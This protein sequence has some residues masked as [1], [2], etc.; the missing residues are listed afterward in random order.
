MVQIRECLILTCLI[1]FALEASAQD[2]HQNENQRIAASEIVGKIRS[3]VPVAYENVYID[4][5]LNL[6]KIERPVVSPLRMI[7]STINGSF[8][9]NGITFMSSLD[10]GG[11]VIS[12]NFTAVGVKFDSDASFAGAHFLRGA[13]FHLAKF[14]GIANFVGANFHGP[15]SLDYAQFSKLASFEGAAFWN[16]ASFANAQFLGDTSLEKAHFLNGASMEFTRFNQLV[17]F[18]RSVFHGEVSFANSEFRGTAN[19]I[20]VKFD[21]N[22]I[23]MGARF[24]SDATF[25]GSIFSKAAVFGLTT[26]EGFSDFSNAVFDSVAF[27][28]LAKLEDNTRFVNTTFNSDLIL[29]SSRIYTMQMENA[30]FS[31]NSKVALNEADF[32]RVIA[33]WSSLKDHLV[34]DS[35]AYLALVKNYKN[36]E[37]RDDADDCYYQYRRIT[38]SMEPWGLAK[39]IDVISWLSCGYGVRPSYTIFWSMFLIFIFGILF[40]A[41]NGVR[42]IEWEYLSDE[43]VDSDTKQEEPD[44]EEKEEMEEAPKERL[45]FADAL[46]F[47]AMSFTAQSPPSLYPVG[48]YKHIGMIEGIL[49]WFLLGLFVV[50]LSGM[51][52]R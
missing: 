33:R 51:L 24:Y 40:W 26:F 45:S 12:G 14:G 36:L 20:R 9:M 21:D 38:Q 6:S 23:F 32:T 28:G 19:F 16:Y 35:A 48:I 13:A 46:Y 30:T 5:D 15:V 42:E 10:L 39:L 50:V 44:S 41:G 34:Y 22:A 1:V 3:G 43:P 25:S 7:N 27:F 11:T 17:S 4:G 31:A 49:G 52:I 18:W 37:W 2:I 47:S 8:N 29:T